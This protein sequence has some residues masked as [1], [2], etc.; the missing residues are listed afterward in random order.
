MLCSTCI[1]NTVPVC[2]T[3]CT[4]NDYRGTAVNTQLMGIGPPRR[5][6][7]PT[8]KPTQADLKHW[9]NIVHSMSVLRQ[10]ILN[11]LNAQNPRWLRRLRS[12]VHSP[13]EISTKARQRRQDDNNMA[14]AALHVT[15]HTSRHIFSYLL[16]RRNYAV[17]QAFV[18][19]SI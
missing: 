10:E 9:D 16:I 17:L 14:P 11:Q 6:P 19:H 3:R 7:T 18:V 15:R 1:I 13:A 12:L 4:L 5:T 2:P 8:Y